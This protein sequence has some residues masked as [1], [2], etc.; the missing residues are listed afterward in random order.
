MQ[1]ADDELDERGGREVEARLVADP[2]ARAKVEALG[3][4][5][6]LVRGHLELAA[7]DVEPR[8]AALWREID[9]RLD[10]EV[11]APAATSTATA[12]TTAA[13]TA[14]SPG[15]WSRA[16][17]WF[18]RYRGH[19]ITGALSA[20]AVAAL[21]LVLRPAAPATDSGEATAAGRAVRVLP[22]AERR[23]PEIES[24]DTP[25]A[26]STVMQLKDED[27]NVAVIWVTPEDT[28]EGI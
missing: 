16:S 8:F 9:K 25:G 11:T 5:G 26:S 1:H 20:G 24:L 14:A 6:E 10:H 4:L 15:L 7:D 17:R 19:V 22:V 27:G 12:S 21:A 28:V 3:E 23:A 13:A 18:D 2:V